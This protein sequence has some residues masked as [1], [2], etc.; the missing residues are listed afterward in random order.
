MIDLAI[1]YMSDET[2][3][4]CGS[5][6]VMVYANSLRDNFI[7]K[8]VI[9]THRM[10]EKQE[11][12]FVAMGFEVF[13]IPAP[14]DHIFFHRWKAVHDYLCEGDYGHV[15]MTDCRDVLF[16]RDPMEEIGFFLGR[17][18]EMI[19]LS[20]EG[21]THM[22]SAWNFNEQQQLSSSIRTGQ[23]EFLDWKVINAGVVA[24][25]Q[26]A[27]RDFAFTMYMATLVRAREDTT[28]QC[29]LN[30]LYYTR[31]CN[32]YLAADPLISRFAATGNTMKER[33]MP[34]E[35]IGGEL[36]MDGRSFAIFHQWDRTPHRGEILTA[37]GEMR[38]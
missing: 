15:L 24:G 18:P 36:Q 35:W 28:D 3:G 23:Y 30:F 6:M 19:L 5:P 11:A 7:G 21:V 29:Y 25:T 22:E 9:L 1:T 20:D 27:L 2:K 13:R 12:I 37:H 34:F 10:A 8:R 14:E 16:Q 31:R 33:D 32:F 38:E 4:F 17:F 26:S